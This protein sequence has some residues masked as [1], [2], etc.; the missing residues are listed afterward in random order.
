MF[1][2]LKTF[3]HEKSQFVESSKLEY[4]LGQK[5]HKHQKK[6]A[7]LTNLLLTNQKFMIHTKIYTAWINTMYQVLNKQ[8]FKM[9]ARY[10]VFGQTNSFVVTEGIRDG[11]RSLDLKVALL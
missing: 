3:Q 5:N 7:P 1:F 9:I 8:L 4:I 6:V 11:R 10:L 2:F